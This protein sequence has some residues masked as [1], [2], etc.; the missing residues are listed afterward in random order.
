MLIET[1]TNP[2]FLEENESKYQIKVLVNQVFD[3]IYKDDA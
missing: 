2:K 3:L 1:F